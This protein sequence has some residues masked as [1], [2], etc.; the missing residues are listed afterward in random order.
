MISPRLA[1]AVA[2]EVKLNLL[3]MPRSSYTAKNT[4]ENLAN[5]ELKLSETVDIGQFDMKHSFSSQCL[6]HGVHI[7]NLHKLTSYS[8]KCP[9]S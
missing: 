6:K 1:Y 5:Y 7:M 4:S 9:K 8:E 2:I 3:D